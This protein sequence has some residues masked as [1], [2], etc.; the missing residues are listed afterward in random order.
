ML[1]NKIKILKKTGFFHVFGGNVINKIIAFM[2]SIILVR[3]LTKDE[4][5]IFTYAWNI[6][7]IVLIANGLGVESG[8][9]QMCSEHSGDENYANK[10]CNYGSRY[11]VKFDFLLTAILISIGLFFPL[12]IEGADKLLIFMSFLPMVSLVYS[13]NIIY[14]RSQKRNQDFAKLSVFNTVLLLVISVVCALLFREKGLVLGYYGAYTLSI[15]FAWKFLDIHLVTHKNKISKEDKKALL[16]ISFV[17]MC[18]NGLSQLLYLLDIFV[19]GLV[20]K[21]EA[22]LASYKVATIIPSALAFIPLALITYL[23]PYFAEKR[24]DGEWCLDKYKK[25]LLYLGIFNAGISLTLFAFAPLIIKIFFGTVYMD[26]IPVFRILAVNYLFAGTF[27]I[28]SG[29][30]LVTQRKLGF[31][32]FVALISGAVNV[33]ADFYLISSMGSVGAALATVLVVI[34]SSILSTTYLIYTFYKNKKK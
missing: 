3:I 19:L 7:S 11:G 34:V 23:Y 16:S 20:D 12:T 31:N 17:S 27:R 29:N 6:Y 24:N 26:A 15:I 14:L 9:L 13:L 1:K 30:L 18:N 21:Q 2:S 10:I 8:I 5:G 33:V 32:L 22:T 4:Y 28:F 25:I